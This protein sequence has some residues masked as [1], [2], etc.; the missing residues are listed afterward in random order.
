[1][2]NSFRVLVVED[3]RLDGHL[4]STMLAE[5]NGRR[6]MDFD[7]LIT[8]TLNDCLVALKDREDLPNG[9]FDVILLDLYLPDC[10]GLETLSRLLELTRQV[11]VVVLTALDD[12]AIAIQ[13]VHLGA[14]DYLVKWHGDSQLLKRAIRY[15]IERKKIQVTLERRNLELR[16]LY[17]T[18]IE[19]NSHNDLDALLKAI[20]AR[21]AKLIGVT[22]G[23]LYLVDEESQTI[24][25][26]YTSET[27]DK[28]KGV[29]MKFGE[30]ISGRAAESGQVMSV[31]D[32]STWQ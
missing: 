9:P 10:Q 30:G 5:R 21:S 7:V 16:E 3:N 12:E 15:A 24:R 22:I 1:M 23:G 13:S 31:S 32:Y 19:I 26:A 8:S 18:S 29:T 17:K 6:E 2:G 14:Q 27:V 11:P 25:L 4:I 28:Y 20:V